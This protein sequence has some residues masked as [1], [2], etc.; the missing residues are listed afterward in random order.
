MHM[1]DENANAP[2]CIHVHACVRMNI[3]ENANARTVGPINELL[4]VGACCFWTVSEE[5]HVCFS[6][7]Y[8]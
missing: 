3:H 8:H 5:L 2:K 1:L 6:V 4:V 7:S